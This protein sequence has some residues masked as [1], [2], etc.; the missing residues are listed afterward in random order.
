M[1]N[2]YPA[3]P[4]SSLV[5]YP[6]EPVRRA[7]GSHT[8]DFVLETTHSLDLNHTS[9]SLDLITTVTHDDQYP[10]VLQYHSGSGAPDK[11]GQYTYKLNQ[12]KFETLGGIW[13]TT[14]VLW[15]NANNKWSDELWTAL[16]EN[17]YIDEGRLYIHGTDVPA[18]TKYITG[19]EEGTYTT[20]N[21]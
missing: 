14:D 17:S 12:R 15:T 9:F 10:I 3:N 20:Y 1:L 6:D 11:D 4:T 13:G 8:Y 16:S 18:F 7:S 21:G 19:N 2:I 5:S